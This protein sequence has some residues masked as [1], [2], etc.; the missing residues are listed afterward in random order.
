MGM[1]LAC[2]TTWTRHLE[3]PFLALPLSY[4][5]LLF[6]HMYSSRATLSDTLLHPMT[7]PICRAIWASPLKVMLTVAS[8]ASLVAQMVNNPP[9]MKETRV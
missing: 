9:T 3:D 1:V 6:F 8:R 4:L 5:P 2:Y 7:L